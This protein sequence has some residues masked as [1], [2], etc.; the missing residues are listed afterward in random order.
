MI[1]VRR[2]YPSSEA[3][4]LI[5]YGAIMASVF[6][7]LSKRRLSLTLTRNKAIEPAND[8]KSERGDAV[9]SSRDSEIDS[10][11]VADSGGYDSDDDES[12]GMFLCFVWSR[13]STSRILHS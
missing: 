1:Y 3:C 7:K 10:D 9:S 12:I 6:R 11:S 13:S 8:T 5:V 2:C 4:C